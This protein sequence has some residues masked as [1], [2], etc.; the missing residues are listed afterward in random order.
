MNKGAAVN[1]LLRTKWDYILAIG[2]DYTDEDMFLALPSS[3][4]T[5]NVGMQDTN[6]RFQLGGVDEVLQLIQTIID[7]SEEQLS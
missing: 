3:A 5:I 4:Y 2:D 6:A 7:D 1:E